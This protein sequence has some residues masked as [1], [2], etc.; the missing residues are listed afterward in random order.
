MIEIKKGHVKKCGEIKK[1]PRCYCFDAPKPRNTLAAH[2]HKQDR[3]WDKRNEKG[4]ANPRIARRQ[5][6]G[7][8][9]L[10]HFVTFLPAL[11]IAVRGG[12]GRA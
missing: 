4:L 11:S 6:H 3:R 12:C 10:R 1:E 8:S 9:A 2:S 5:G 7:S